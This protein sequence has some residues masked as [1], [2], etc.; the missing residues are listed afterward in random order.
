LTG[1]KL[2]YVDGTR[3]PAVVIAAGERRPSDSIE[4]ELPKGVRLV[5]TEG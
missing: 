3:H 4:L 5:E 2:F 1:P